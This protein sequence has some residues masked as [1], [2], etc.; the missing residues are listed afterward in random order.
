ML[1]VFEGPDGAGK[2]TLAEAVRKKTHAMNVHCGPPVNGQAKQNWERMASQASASNPLVFDRLHW[3]DYAYRHYRGDDGELGLDGITAFDEWL[4]RRGA[5]IVLITADAD[6]LKRR[7]ELLGDEDYI[8]LDDLP[9]IVADYELMYK[10]SHAA[11][12]SP[13][14]VNS[15]AVSLDTLIGMADGIVKRATDNWNR[16]TK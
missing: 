12:K 1:I 5:L 2:S 4:V 14:Y 6:V 9:S 3:G 7:L 10:R 16:W 13:L 11:T 15:G 8:N